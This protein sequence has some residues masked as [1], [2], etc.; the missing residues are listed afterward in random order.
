MTP[1]NFI[2]NEKR[3]LRVKNNFKQLNPKLFGLLILK[4]VY[5]RTVK[6]MFSLG[7]VRE[8]NVSKIMF[9]NKFK[10]KWKKYERTRF[11]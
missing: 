10:R 11:I 9:C 1:E 8:G 3:E 5:K 7:A 4:L 6:E 2:E